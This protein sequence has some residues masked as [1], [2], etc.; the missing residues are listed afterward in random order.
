[1]R[2]AK[3][4]RIEGKTDYKRRLKLLKAGVPR[5]VIRKS[6][7]NILIQLVESK[8]ARDFPRVGVFSREL[9]KVGWPD[10]FKGSLKSISAAYLT[11]LLFG[12]KMIKHK[13]KEGIVD[14]GLMRST[15]GSKIYAAVKGIADAGVEIKCNKKMFPSQERIEGK[16]LKKDFS[17]N[18]KKI[19]EKI[20]H[21]I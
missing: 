18:F 4:R 9:L 12:K 10:E 17:V 19:K 16:N 7:R 15:K 14:I 6:N 13:L 8:E 3:R 20:E 1:M 11:G 21:E 2:I 5:V